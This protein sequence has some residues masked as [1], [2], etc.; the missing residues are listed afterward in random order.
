MSLLNKNN[1]NTIHYVNHLKIYLL[2]RHRWSEVG[3]GRHRRVP[4]VK[5]GLLLVTGTTLHGCNLTN[6]CIRKYHLHF[7]IK[8]TMGG[9]A[10]KIRGYIKQGAGRLVTI[11]LINID[12]RCEF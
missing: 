8:A 10:D 12:C 5:V 9:T 7:F 3:V 6:I 4:K 2:G 1:I 11:V